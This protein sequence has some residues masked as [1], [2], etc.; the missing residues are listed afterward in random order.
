MLKYV[1]KYTVMKWFCDLFDLFEDLQQFRARNINDSFRAAVEKC[2]ED[3][4]NNNNINNKNSITNIDKSIKGDNNKTNK[5]EKTDDTRKHKYDVKKVKKLKEKST[6]L[7]DSKHH[8][9]HFNQ[10]NNK[11]LTKENLEKGHKADKFEGFKE[12]RKIE[13]ASPNKK[14]RVRL[15]LSSFLKLVFVFIFCSF[16]HNTC[17]LNLFYRFNLS[18]LF[19]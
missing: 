13:S 12:G 1:L 7:N 18:I 14:D 11:P 8:H 2:L 15:N 6:Q 3:N 9:R 4:N 5:N 10:T 19:I 17:S 16:I